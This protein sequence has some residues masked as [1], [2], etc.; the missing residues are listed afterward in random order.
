MASSVMT[1]RIVGILKSRLAACTVNEHLVSAVNM[2]HNLGRLR[3][4]RTG[5]IEACQAVATSRRAGS[6]MAIVIHCDN[7]PPCVSRHADEQAMRRW[8]CAVRWPRRF[9]SPCSGLLGHHVTFSVG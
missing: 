1:L 6:R 8:R 5:N 9:V 7:R 2:C 3:E 4:M